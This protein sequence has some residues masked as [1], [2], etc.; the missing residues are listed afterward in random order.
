MLDKIGNL[1]T[2]LLDRFLPSTDAEALSC[3]VQCNSRHHWQEFC[4]RDGG[5]CYW[6][7]DESINRC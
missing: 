5:G 2:L 7:G 4:C 1:G 6:R 3:T